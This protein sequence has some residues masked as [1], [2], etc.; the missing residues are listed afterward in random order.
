MLVDYPGDSRYYPR[1]VAAEVVGGDERRVRV[2]YQVGIG[3][4]AFAFHMEVSRSPASPDRLASR[5]RSQPRPFRENSGYWQ[6]DEAAAASLVTYAIAVR[7]MLPAI[8]T[9][10]PRRKPHR[11]GR[12]DAQAVEAGPGTR[13]ERVR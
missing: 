3:P 11:D 10:A 1:V 4:F 8:I 6:V 7:T 2:R 12:G 5:R 9:R 13:S